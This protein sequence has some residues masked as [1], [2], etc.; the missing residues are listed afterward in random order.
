MN[1]LYKAYAR[2]YQAN[3]RF[4]TRFIDFREP[5]VISEEDSLLKVP[6]ILKKEHKS[7]PLIVTL[8]SIYKLGLTDKLQRILRGNGYEFEIFYRVDENP[9]TDNVN[10]GLVVYKGSKCDCVIAFGGGS[11]IDCSKM[12]A[13]LSANSKK[14]ISDLRGLLKVRKKPDLLIAIPTTAGS[15]SEAT[16]AAVIS[17]HK[18]HS[19]FTVNDPKLVPMY[20]IFDPHLLVGLPAK[21]TSTTG[22][23]ALCHAVEAYLGN[24]NT[25]KTKKYAEEAI[26]DIFNS[27]VNSYK[28]PLDLDLRL[29]MQV[30]S[31]KAGIAFTRAYVGYVHAMAHALGAFYNV[32]HG[33]AISIVFPYVLNVYGKKAIKKEA[34][35][36]DL[37]HVSGDAMTEADKAAKFIMAIWKMEDE[38]NIPHTIK[39]FAKPEDFPEMAK[40]VLK[41]A[42]PL[43]PVPKLL[44][45][46]D[47]IRVYK[48]MYRD[49]KK[50]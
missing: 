7:H 37:V 30:A 16:V 8:P 39:G 21:V 33:L 20:A 35:L 32:P 1:F 43:Y 10:D 48:M 50:D 31:D 40:H 47:I 18:T 11:A 13:A 6:E 41:E 3:M 28:K 46:N 42:Y 29:K 19:K 17:D 49:E 4:L 2:I 45:K 9:T 34:K 5:V 36:A 24:S 22:I 44:S 26:V 12:I 27:L 38:M 14:T 23:D 15:G 25:K